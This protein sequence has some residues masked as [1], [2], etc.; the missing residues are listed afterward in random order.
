MA[1]TVELLGEREGGG[2]DVDAPAGN[3]ETLGHPRAGL[4]QRTDVQPV[5]LTR[6]CEDAG[7]LVVGENAPLAG[8]VAARALRRLSRGMDTG[9]SRSSRAKAY[10]ADSTARCDVIV[11]AFKPSLRSEATYARTSA[12]PMDDR[13]RAPNSALRRRRPLL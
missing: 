7:E 12:F 6:G 13:R 1:G 4:S 3:A 11:F 2:L 10:S 9:M 8:V 5:A